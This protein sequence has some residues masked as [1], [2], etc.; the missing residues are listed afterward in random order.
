MLPPTWMF[1]ITNPGYQILPRLMRHLAN[2][3]SQILTAGEDHDAKSVLDT[4]N[5]EVQ[6]ILDAYWSTH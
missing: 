2:A 5:V 4:T 1:P 6:K 3:Q